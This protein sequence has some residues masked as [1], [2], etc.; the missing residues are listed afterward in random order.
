[1]RVLVLF[2]LL[3]G[4]IGLS[5]YSSKDK[6]GDTGAATTV[7]AGP[8]SASPGQ[9]D[10]GTVAVGSEVSEEVIVRNTSG[11][12]VR[13]I[14]AL[15][16]SGVFSLTETSLTIA[17]DEESVLS[18]AFS[19]DAGEIYDASVT[20]TDAEGTS[21]LI[22]LTGA[23]EGAPT[24]TTLTDTGTTP[25]DTGTTPTTGTDGNVTVSPASYD[26]GQLDSEAATSTTFTI[27]N[28]GGDDL[29]IS[30]VDASP[31]VFAATTTMALPA[32]IRSGATG[33]VT[34]TFT[35]GNVGTF[36]GVLEVL[37]DDPDSPTLRVPL[38]GEGAD[39]C[40]VCSGLIDVD[41]GADPY[42]MEFYALG[43][44]DDEQ[45]IIVQ[46]VG[47]MDLAVSDVYVN[48]DSIF[49]CGTFTLSGWRTAQTLAPNDS[50]SF[51]ITYSVTGLCADVPNG[52]LD[53]NIL[54]ILS[55]D[56]SQGDYEIDLTGVGAA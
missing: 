16:G 7:S 31:G 23:G 1:M 14:A 53:W 18:V 12:I 41:A 37:S 3:S 48:N 51:S 13:L 15:Q 40:S 17:P 4:C 9:L 45:E 11:D 44:F 24:E 22:A 39:L 46:N 49:T 54:H 43:P 42:T 55:D 8:F 33:S 50:L 27:R 52:T 34:V 35:P 25:T 6:E 30:D 19:P 10:F 29:L 38:T 26:F 28:T 20:L 36:N 47:D 5:P 56:P 21:L 32:V 2:L